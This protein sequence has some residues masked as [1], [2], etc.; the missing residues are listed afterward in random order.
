MNCMEC[1]RGGVHRAAVALCHSCSGALSLP[2]M[3]ILRKVLR[4]QL[5][6][7]FIAVMTAGIG[8]GYLSNALMS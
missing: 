4:P 1:E 6:A 5:L 8:V 7:V 2:E 3:V